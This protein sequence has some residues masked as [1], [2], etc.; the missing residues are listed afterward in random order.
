MTKYGTSKDILFD[1]SGL[2]QSQD[3]GKESIFEVEVSQADSTTSSSRMTSREDLQLNVDIWISNRSGGLLLSTLTAILLMSEEKKVTGM[4]KI[5]VG[6]MWNVV[7]KLRT[8][9]WKVL[10]L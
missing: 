3:S 6:P 2:C 10:K 5:C 1:L 8:L 9:A 4:W 7:S